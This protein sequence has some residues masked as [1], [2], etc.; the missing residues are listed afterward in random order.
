MRIGAPSVKPLRDR[1]RGDLG[2]ARSPMAKQEQHI[3]AID[4]AFMREVPGKPLDDPASRLRDGRLTTPVKRAQPSIADHP[5]GKNQRAECDDPAGPHQLLKPGKIGRTRAEKME[6]PPAHRSGEGAGGKG[7]GEGVTLNEA[8]FRQTPLSSFEH[9]KRTVEQRYAFFPT[10]IGICSENQRTA[11]KIEYRPIA[12]CG[13]EPFHRLAV[14][15][16]SAA[17]YEAII[18]PVPDQKV[19][20]RCHTVVICHPIPGGQRGSYAGWQI[21]EHFAKLRGR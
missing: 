4:G 7:R 18:R 12:A 8:S 19:V 16:F 2:S 3:T 17:P 5:I 10:A 11:A 15:A 21:F 13:K 20:P 9:A 1:P 14:G 6:H